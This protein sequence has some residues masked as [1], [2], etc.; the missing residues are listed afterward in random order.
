[1]LGLQYLVLTVGS[2]AAETVI[3]HLLVQHYAI[4]ETGASR[5]GCK[6][7]SAT[8]DPHPELRGTETAA[9][10]ARREFEGNDASG[11]TS[12]SDSRLSEADVQLWTH[13]GLLRRRLRRADKGHWR[14][15]L[16]ERRN[17]ELHHGPVGDAD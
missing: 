6:Y 9:H 11:I 2:D 7:A 4:P 13:G 14:S 10:D 17:L 16:N 12:G 15:E 1:M 5:S 8:G 3:P